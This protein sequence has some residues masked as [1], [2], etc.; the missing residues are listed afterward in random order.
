[1][2]STGDAAMLIYFVTFLRWVIVAKKPRWGPFIKYIRLE[3]GEGRSSERTRVE[4]LAVPT[5]TYDSSHTGRHT[6]LE[7]VLKL[8]YLVERGLRCMCGA[9]GGISTALFGT[10]RE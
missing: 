6:A 3:Y 7:N 1:M 2:I 4:R 10:T 5:I 9:D 8:C